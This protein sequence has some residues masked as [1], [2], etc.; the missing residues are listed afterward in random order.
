MTHV[1]DETARQMH[2]DQRVEAQLVLLADALDRDNPQRLR[3]A[4]HAVLRL[5]Y[6]N[7]RARRNRRATRIAALSHRL[8][9]I[10]PTLS[11]HATAHRQDALT[12]LMNRGALDQD[13]PRLV[14]MST[15]AQT[16]L[17]VLMI[18]VDHFKRVNDTYGHPTGDRVLRA[19][20]DT[21]ARAFAQT[22]DYRARYGGEEF[23]VVLPQTDREEAVGRAHHFLAMLRALDVEHDA[24]RLRM[25]ASVGIAGLHAAETSSDVIARADQALYAAKRGGRDQVAVAPM[26]I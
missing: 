13:L 18:D 9:T 25:T 19:I 16:P 3:D 17:A 21:L 23:C 22:H 8:K 2:D 6:D 14:A 11:D 1:R 4:A 5:V 24:G 26:P 12:G 15:F 10:E 7:V 20:A